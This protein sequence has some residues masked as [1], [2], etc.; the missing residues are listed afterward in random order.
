ME[1][2][3]LRDLLQRAFRRGPADTAR[4]LFDRLVPGRPRC[5]GAALQ[6]VAGRH[7]LEIGG[8]SEAFGR[9]G[10]LPVYARAGSLDNVV[11]AARSVWSEGAPDGGPFVFAPGRPAG[12]TWIREA[13]RLDGI[14]DASYAFAVSSH[15]LEHVANPLGAL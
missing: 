7:G 10:L 11:F 13:T 6:A 3:S 9:R 1:P 12:R 5:A 2:G 14:A 8:P 4:A 15:C